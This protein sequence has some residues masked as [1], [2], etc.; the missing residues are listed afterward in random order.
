MGELWALCALGGTS[1]ARRATAARF[2]CH[3]HAARVYTMSLVRVRVHDVVES[4]R[5]NRVYSD[6]KCIFCEYLALFA[7]CEEHAVARALAHEA[8]TFMVSQACSHVGKYD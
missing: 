6:R 3:T 5:P 8:R 7:A 4:D 1:A 2:I